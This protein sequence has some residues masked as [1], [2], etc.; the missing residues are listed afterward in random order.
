MICEE[1]TR[2]LKRYETSTSA[3]SDAVLELHRKI[4]TSPKDEYERL[5]RISSD[6]RVK[7]EQARLAIRDC[8]NDSHCRPDV[9][10]TSPQ[11]ALGR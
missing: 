1:K 5:E 6:A 10:K 4:C 7:S 2:S 11:D 9:R 3:F 8:A